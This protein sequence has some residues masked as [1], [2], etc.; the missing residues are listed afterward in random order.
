MS[1]LFF[2][3]LPLVA[4][5]VKAFI[6]L[7]V[8]QSYCCCL[9]V[10]ILKLSMKIPHFSVDFR[11][12]L[13]FTSSVPCCDVTRLDKGQGRSVCSFLPPPE[14]KGREPGENTEIQSLFTNK[15]KV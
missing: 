6:I 9:Q 13:C 3:V 12:A 8:T 10:S 15:S 14:F 7:N 11:Q 1:R 2:G 5:T 4:L